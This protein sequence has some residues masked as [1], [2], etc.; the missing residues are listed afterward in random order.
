MMRTKNINNSGLYYTERN[1]RGQK[2][3]MGGSIV[4]IN[5]HVRARVGGGTK[6]IGKFQI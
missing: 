1:A 4:Q 2:L 5:L 3:V 6:W